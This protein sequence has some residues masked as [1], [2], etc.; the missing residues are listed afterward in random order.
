MKSLIFLSL[1]LLTLSISLKAQ[2][3]TSE[4]DA[5]ADTNYLKTLPWYGNNNYLERFL[6]RIPSIH[7]Y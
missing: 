6:D 5:K 2:S 7:H 1:F 4:C 3:D